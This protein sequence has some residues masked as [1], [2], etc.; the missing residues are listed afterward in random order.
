MIKNHRHPLKSFYLGSIMMMLFNE[1]CMAEQSGFFATSK[2]VPSVT[3]Y[4]VGFASVAT[5]VSTYESK[6][7]SNYSYAKEDAAAFI[8]SEGDI[9]GVQLEHAWRD[10]LVSD[11]TPK[12]SQNSFAEHVLV[13]N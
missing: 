13:W 6:L 2:Q 4:Y 9:H 12:L 11:H 7:F 5:S 10:Y 3:T 8:A 1:S